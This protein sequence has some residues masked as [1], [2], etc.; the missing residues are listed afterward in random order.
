MSRNESSNYS[1]N[2]NHKLTSLGFWSAVIMTITV[3][4][5]GI[6]AST[7]MKIP[8]LVSGTILIPVFILLIAC[9]HEYSPANRKFYSRL[10]LLFTMGYAVLIGFNYYMQLTLVQNNLYTDVFA[11]DDP[12][13]IM[14]V[15]EVI[16]YGFMG[17]ATL[18]TAFVF[19]NGKLENAIRWLF[20]VNGILGIG[21]MIGYA[22]GLSLNILAGG[23]IVWD[24]IMPLSSILLAVLFRRIL[25]I[26]NL[27]QP[28]PAA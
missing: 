2:M 24:I 3:I 22:L 6:T 10:G 7:A 17:L 9:I 11:M 18:S 14:W 25:K 27:L 4:F 8:S 19:T 23:L 12:K 20:I 13:S 28:A 21:G 15:I 5:S 16:G 26:N 1:L